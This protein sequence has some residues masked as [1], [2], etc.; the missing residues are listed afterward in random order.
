MSVGGQAARL[1][2]EAEG[3][4]PA[5][6]APRRVRRDIRADAGHGHR[7]RVEVGQPVDAG[8]VLLSSKR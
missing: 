4:A 2:V 8:D 6:E 1:E 5:A 3:Q 7:H